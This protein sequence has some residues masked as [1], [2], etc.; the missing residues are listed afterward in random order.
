MPV[1]LFLFTVAKTI[2]SLQPLTAAGHNYVGHKNVVI[3]INRCTL[4]KLYGKKLASKFQ[5]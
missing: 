1:S 2:W 5:L 4:L 3:A